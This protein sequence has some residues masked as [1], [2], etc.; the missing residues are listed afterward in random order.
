MAYEVDVRRGGPNGFP[1]KIAVD[2]SPLDD[3]AVAYLSPDPFASELRSPILKAMG[4]K[5]AWRARVK[6]LDANGAI[7]DTPWSAWCEFSLGRVTYGEA[8]FRIEG[9]NGTAVRAS[10][11]APAA[12]P[13]TPAAEDRA[14]PPPV[15]KSRRARRR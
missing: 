8:W 4:S 15:K 1:T 3:S 6:R 14:A 5:W 9:L 11:P 2:L 13:E 10:P 7:E 12:A